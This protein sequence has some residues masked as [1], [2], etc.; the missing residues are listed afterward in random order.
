LE[1]LKR[2]IQK[3]PARY[4]CF[5][6]YLQP[7]SNT[8]APVPRLRSIFEPLISCPGVVGLAVGTRPDCLG[9]NVCDYLRDISMRT[10]L[11]VEIGIQSCDDT[12]LARINRS[13]TFAQFTEAC[14]RLSAMNIEITAHVMLGLPGQG[15]ESVRESARAL[16]SLPIQ[17]IKI[18]QLMI[19]EGT[20]MAG[21]YR[22]NRLQPLSLERYSELAGTFLS[23]LRPD[24]FIHRLVADTCSGRGLIAPAW[25]L[26][27]MKALAHIDRY[28]ADNSIRQGRDYGA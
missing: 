21:L 15:D 3:A 20:P 17:G 13:H 25:S 28:L 19:I 11:N 27:K 18:H 9:Q 16:S 12:V 26:D 5:I 1:Q 24:Q 23:H 8:Y 4:K 10:Y 6:A 7:F 22:E 2:A 14:A